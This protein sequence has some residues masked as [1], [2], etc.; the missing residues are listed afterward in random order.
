[1]RV[2]K[3]E[4]EERYQAYLTAVYCFHMRVDDVEEK[5]ERQLNA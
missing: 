2:K 4:G 1:M 5:R 3:L